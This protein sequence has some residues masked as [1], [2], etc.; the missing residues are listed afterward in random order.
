MR[1]YGG[2]IG[3][4]QGRGVMHVH[5]ITVPPPGDD[6]DETDPQQVVDEVAP[7]VVGNSQ[8]RRAEGEAENGESSELEDEEHDFGYAASSS[9]EESEPEEDDMMTGEG[10]GE[11]SDTDDSDDEDPD[12]GPED[13]EEPVDEDELVYASVGFRRK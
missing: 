2:G 11:Q 1:F 9:E 12:L 13:G 3:H 5:P 7:Q 8:G 10:A 4:Q 6:C